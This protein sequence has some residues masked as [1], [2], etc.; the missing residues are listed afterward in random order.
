MRF[1]KKETKIG[2]LRKLVQYKK[3]GWEVIK[4]CPGQFYF[5]SPIREKIDKRILLAYDNT[6]MEVHSEYEELQVSYLE[7]VKQ[8]L[9]PLIK[10]YFKKYSQEKF[11]FV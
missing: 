5:L 2:L 8:G 9:L 10:N 6:N 1:R 4:V 7:N 11:T 3:E